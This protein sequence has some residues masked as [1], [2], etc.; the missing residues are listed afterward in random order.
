MFTKHEPAT[1]RAAQQEPFTEGQNH[2]RFTRGA[3]GF[4]RANMQ[5]HPNSPKA[6]CNATATRCTK[7]RATPTHS[8]ARSKTAPGLWCWMTHHSMQCATS[9]SAMGFICLSSA[10]PAQ[11]RGHHIGLLALLRSSSAHNSLLSICRARPR[12]GCAGDAAGQCDGRNAQADAQRR[13]MVCPMVRLEAA[14]TPV[15]STRR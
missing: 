11:R 9:A 7:T 3:S 10:V 14:Y 6:H 8:A 5:P 15:G 4:Q 1:C 12:T 13:S 2:K